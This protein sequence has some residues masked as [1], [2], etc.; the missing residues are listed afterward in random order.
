MIMVEAILFLLLM[1][2]LMGLCAYTYLVI[3]TYE[4]VGVWTFEFKDGH[5]GIF[6]YPKWMLFWLEKL[7]NK[8]GKVDGK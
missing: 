2:I 6:K 7:L 1:Y 4:F 5:V 8:V 3:K